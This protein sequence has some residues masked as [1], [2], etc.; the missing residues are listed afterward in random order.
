LLGDQLVDRTIEGFP[1]LDLACG[2]GRPKRSAPIG[3][4]LKHRAADDAANAFATSPR[5]VQ[6]GKDVGMIAGE[7][8]QQL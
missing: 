1:V 5:N 8:A 7:A 2:R 3:A 4:Q 6:R